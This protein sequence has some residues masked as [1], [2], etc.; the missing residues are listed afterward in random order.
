MTPIDITP[1]PSEPARAAALKR[2][3]AWFKQHRWQPFDFQREAWADYLAGKS[4]LI[5]A[6]TGTGKTYAVALPPLMEWLAEFPD[7]DAWPKETPLRVL[8]ITPLRA[9]AN[10]TV[11]SILAPI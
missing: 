4:G 10:D 7:E 5:H 11:K 2:G 8:W 6:P 9:L 3:L 1:A